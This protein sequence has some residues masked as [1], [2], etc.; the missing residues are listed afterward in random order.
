MIVVDTSAWI[1]YLRRTGSEENRVLR[2]AVEGQRQ[3][4]LPD[5]ARMELLAGVRDTGVDDLIAFLA[6]FAPV[7]THSP[8]DHDIAASLYRRARASGTTVR[9]LVNCLVA[10]A[11]LRLDAPVLARD[12]DFE[13][14][15]SVSDLRL[16]G[17]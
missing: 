4:G 16:A 9:S 14:L 1:E 7:P 5:V 15:A 12:R 11:A 8:G 13:I 3:L 17:R 10:S 6:R 2:A